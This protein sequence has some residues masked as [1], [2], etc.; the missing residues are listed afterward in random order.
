MKLIIEFDPWAEKDAA[1]RA[2]EAL[3]TLG[4]PAELR[5]KNFRRPITVPSGP[6]VFDPVEPSTTDIP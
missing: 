5:E 4:L 2:E 1:E 3:R 6:V